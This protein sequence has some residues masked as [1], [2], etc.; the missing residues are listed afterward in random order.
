MET[1]GLISLE[2]RFCPLDKKLDFAG[3][4]KT[5]ACY[6]GISLKALKSVDGYEFQG[7]SLFIARVNILSCDTLEE[8]VEIRSQSSW[9]P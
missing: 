1:G 8:K 6:R 2:D 3:H 5:L 7:E 4:E 9:P